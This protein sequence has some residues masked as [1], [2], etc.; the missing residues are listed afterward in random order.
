VTRWF[1]KA[2]ET[3]EG[4]SEIQDAGNAELKKLIEALAKSHN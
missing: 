3:M 4:Y 2:E 1:S